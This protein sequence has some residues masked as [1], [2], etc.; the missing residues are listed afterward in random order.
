MSETKRAR[1]AIRAVRLGPSDGRTAGRLFAMMAAVFDEA[2]ETLSDAYLDR[3]L[4]RDEFWVI[5]A[6]SGDDVVGGLTAHA[7]PMT[8]T[9]SR[10]LFIYDVAVREDHQRQGVGRRLLE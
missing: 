2:H 8:R 6:F 4:A 5:A 1:P 7:L 9:E 10:E 3:L